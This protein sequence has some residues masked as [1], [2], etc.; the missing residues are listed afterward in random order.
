MAVGLT[1]TRELDAFAKIVL[2]VG[3]IKPEGILTVGTAWMLRQD[4]LFATTRH[5]VGSDDADLCILM[6]RIDGLSQYQDLSDRSFQF[7]AA[8]VEELDPIRDLLILRARGIRFNGNLP[9]I[10]SLDD[11]LVGEEL[12]SFGYPHAN[13]RVVLTTQFSRLGAKLYL[14]SAGT[15]PKYGILNV[16][17]RPGQS[18]SPIFHPRSGNIVALTV[19][20]FKGQ[21]GGIT[22]GDIDPRE[23]NQTTQCISA[24][25]LKE[26]L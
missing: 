11:V 26:M 7:A 10:G 23:L 9:K 2:P 3:R 14:P 15:K 22:L 25:Y 17:T 6:P 20:V 21:G 13:E 18:G 1:D 24:E 12:L 19:G 16:Q 8:K 4:G 5:V